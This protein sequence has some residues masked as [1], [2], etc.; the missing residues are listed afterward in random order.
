MGAR[1]GERVHSE[2][3]ER[4]DV[5]VL[6]ENGEPG[7]LGDPNVPWR[8][9]GKINWVGGMCP[10]ALAV[11]IGCFTVESSTGGILGLKTYVGL[12]SRP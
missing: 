11:N 6:G 5:G 1:A 10:L 2:E 8:A 4:G 3:A 12:N 9:L 7:V